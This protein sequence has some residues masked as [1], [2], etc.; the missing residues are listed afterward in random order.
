M[1]SDVN[2]NEK[3]IFINLYLL[4]VGYVLKKLFSFMNFN[5]Q[6]W[7]KVTKLYNLGKIN[8]NLY[9]MRALVQPS[10]FRIWAIEIF[11]SNVTEEVSFAGIYIVYTQ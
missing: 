3:Y 7:V 9:L 1:T 11:L 2:I 5:R 4:N 8:G 10:S 6:I